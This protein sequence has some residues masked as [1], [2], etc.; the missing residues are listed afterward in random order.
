MQGAVTGTGAIGN[1]GGGGIDHQQ[2]F[3][4]IDGDVALA[5]HD[6]LPG[7]DPTLLCRWRRDRPAANAQSR[8]STHSETVPNTIIAEFRP[9]RA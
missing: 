2:P 9:A 7:I 4:G 5:A 3:V 1:V 6:L 8:P